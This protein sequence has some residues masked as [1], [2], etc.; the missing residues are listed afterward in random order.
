MIILKEIKQINQLINEIFN[1]GQNAFLDTDYSFVNTAISDEQLTLLCASKVEGA[2][3]KLDQLSLYVFQLNDYM[4]ALN[5]IIKML[6]MTKSYDAVYFFVTRI[7]YEH[8]GTINYT[9]SE[10]TY[11]YRQK[12]FDRFV[13]IVKNCQISKELYIPFILEF[14]KDDQSRLAVWQEPAIEFLKKFEAD[15]SQWFNE[16]V[17]NDPQGYE[18]LCLLCYFSTQKGIKLAIDFYTVGKNDNQIFDLFGQIKKDFLLFLDQELNNL[19]DEILTKV[20]YILLSWGE[21][22]EAKSRLD[23]I[24][25]CTQN[26]ALRNMISSKIGSVQL[27]TFKSEKNFLFAVRRNILDPQERTLGLPFDKCNLT[28]LSGLKADNASYTYLINLLKEEKN[29]LNLERFLSLKNV[30]K[31]ETLEAFANQIFHILDKKFDINCAKWAV[32]LIALFASKENL[33]QMILKLISQ[34]RLK[35]SK[36]LLNCM[37]YSKTDITA[38]LKKLS[39]REEFSAIKDQIVETY[40]DFNNINIQI[41]REQ[42]LPDDFKL[43]TLEH[44]RVI[45]FENFIAGR[46][47]SHDYFDQ[48]FLGNKLYNTLAQDIVFGEFKFG[49]LYSAFVINGRTKTYVYGGHIDDTVVSIIHTIDCD[50][51][52]KHLANIYPNTTFKQF[53]KSYFDVNNFSRNQVSVQSFAGTV[54]NPE[55]FCDNICSYGFYKNKTH[56]TNLYSSIVN[57]MPMLNLVCELEFESNVDEKTTYQTLSNAYFYRLCDC[58]ESN[59]KLITPKQNAISVGSLPA[60]YFSHVLSAITKSIKN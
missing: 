48:L 40:A 39:L 43:G 31:P 3:E 12:M 4:Y 11:N 35:E 2:D 18:M 1:L 54:V 34:N 37:I 53:E 44:E 59:G 16:F 29:L 56:G 49:R 51:R 9:S 24:F 38:I 17:F 36:Y 58:L 6:L 10:K 47:Y 42:L 25:K 14:F 5:N 50:E 33:E 15:N 27:A 41:V 30:F 21:D 55:I 13:E 7:F 52:T 23:E 8:I 57:K 28:Y 46:E 26:I 45:L 60:R 32:R 22:T 20:T 19:T